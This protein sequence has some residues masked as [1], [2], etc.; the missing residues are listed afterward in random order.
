MH[1]AEMLGDDWYLHGDWGIVA[2]P[3][4]ESTAATENAP[5]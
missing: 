5:D 3:E 1:P 2:L 4:P